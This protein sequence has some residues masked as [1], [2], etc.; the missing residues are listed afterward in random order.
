MDGII[1]VYGA[2]DDE[3]VSKAFI[4]TGACQ[5]RGKASTGLAVGNGKGIHIY[6]GL[7]RIAEVID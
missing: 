2:D 1:G 7:G 6:K 4:A 3:L 5:H